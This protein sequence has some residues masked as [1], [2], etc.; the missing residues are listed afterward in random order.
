M[1]FMGLVVTVIFMTSSEFCLRWSLEELSA[2]ASPLPYRETLTATIIKTYPT[3]HVFPGFSPLEKDFRLVKITSPIIVNAE[4]YTLAAYLGGCCVNAYA[5][6]M[7]VDEPMPDYPEPGSGPYEGGETTPQPGGGR[8]G[9]GGAS[10]EWG[11]KRDPETGGGWY[12]PIH[13][14]ESEVIAAR[15]SWARDSGYEECLGHNAFFWVY[16]GDEPEP[17]SDHILNAPFANIDYYGMIVSYPNRICDIHSHLVG[18]ADSQTISRFR[19]HAYILDSGNIYQQNITVKVHENANY[20]A[21]YFPPRELGTSRDAGV[22]VAKRTRVN[23]SCGCRFNGVA[24]VGK[25]AR[26]LIGMFVVQRV[27]GFLGMIPLRN[28]PIQLRRGGY[29]GARFSIN[30]VRKL[31]IRWKIPERSYKRCQKLLRE[32]ILRG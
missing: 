2:L 3:G 29:R 23:N 25:K 11:V 18:F 15:M 5:Y 19:V 4:P 16:R 28:L 26:R 24:A 27:D 30:Q 6:Y 20:P 32:S 22:F 7:P 14:L 8:S 10:G 21:M 31:R 1:Y 12:L 17:S 9:G 13:L